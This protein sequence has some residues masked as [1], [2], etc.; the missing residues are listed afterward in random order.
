MTIATQEWPRL[1]PLILKASKN[2]SENNAF[3]LEEPYAGPPYFTLITNDE[4]F[5]FQGELVVDRNQFQAFRA[6]F[7]RINKGID[8]FF[9]RVDTGLSSG[10]TRLEFFAVPSSFRQVKDTGSTWTFNFDCYTNSLTGE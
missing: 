6:F 4:R 8:P 1:I 10:L 7:D 9:Y 2:S 3:E 5:Y